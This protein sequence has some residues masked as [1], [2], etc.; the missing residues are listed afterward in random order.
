MIT[1]RCPICDRKFSGASLQEL[2]QH[3]FCS[4][5]CRLI[6]LGRWLGERY[7]M[8]AEDAGAATVDEL[9]GEPPFS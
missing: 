2:P 7:R 9:D 3:P 6:D 4:E 5:K 1:G 8:P